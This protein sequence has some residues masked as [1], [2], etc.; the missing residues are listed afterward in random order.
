MGFQVHLQFYFP[1]RVREVP[2]APCAPRPRR[3]SWKPKET[4]QEMWRFQLQGR[5]VTRGRGSFRELRC[6]GGWPRDGPEEVGPP[7]PGEALGVSSGSIPT[8][9]PQPPAAAARGS[10][11]P[12]PAGGDGGEERNPP[13]SP[14]RKQ[15]NFPEDFLLPNPT[16][17]REKRRK[18][19]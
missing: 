15:Q 1:Q 13:S 4:G 12:Q 3:R 17:Q 11:C 5:Q 6:T 16:L 8:K 2:P 7:A 9:P 19:P 14:F 10:P 18:E